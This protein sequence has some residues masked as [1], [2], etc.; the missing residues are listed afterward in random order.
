MS[1]SKNNDTSVAVSSESESAHDAT[2][3][4][5]TAKRSGVAFIADDSTTI[6]DGELS[7]EAA[8]TAL[9]TEEEKKL[10][11]KV[12]W[13]LIPLLCMLYLVKK[14]DESNV[15]CIEL[16]LGEAKTHIN[17]GFQCTNHEQRNESKHHDPA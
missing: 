13:R 9:T 16:G 8:L 5:K 10:L 3:N 17:S 15:S 14:L 6:A 1:P 12:D 2:Q 11:R 7:R 4:L